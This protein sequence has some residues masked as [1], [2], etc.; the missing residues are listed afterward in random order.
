MNEKTIIDKEPYLKQDSP[1]QEV[2]TLSDRA[3]PYASNTVTLQGQEMDAKIA[4]FVEYVYSGALPAI[5]E[6][7]TP[8][9]Q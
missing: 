8:Y 6:D 9:K 5:P 4:P 7:F 3:M 1:S 2:S